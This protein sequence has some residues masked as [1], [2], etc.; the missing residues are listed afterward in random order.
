KIDEIRAEYVQNLLF[1]SNIFEGAAKE[2][3]NLEKI[4]KH[5]KEEINLDINVDILSGLD[6]EELFEKMNSVLKK[7]YDDK[8][9]V[10]ER[11]VQS[12]VARELYL[13]ELDSAWREH[14][15][16]MDNMKT[17]IRLRAYNQKDPLVEYKKE[18]FNLF[19]ELINDIK[20]NTIKTLQIIQFRMES[21]EDEAKR[22]AEQLELQRKVNEAAIKLSTQDDESSV[23][24]KPARNEPCPCGS[25]KKYKQCCGKSGPKKGAFAS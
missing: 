17:G 5:I 18:S 19:G 24:K 3:F 22:M 10:L 21:A 23:Q 15:Y 25:G 14:L 16:A 12:E 8:M 1:T 20:F 9:G 7:S 6:Y 13:K 2:D 4:V 11:E